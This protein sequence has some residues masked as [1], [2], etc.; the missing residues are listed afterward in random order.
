[1]RRSK[2]ALFFAAVFFLTTLFV[3]AFAFADDATAKLHFE[4]GIHLYDQQPPD[5]EG[6]LAEFR[7]AEKNKPSPGIKRNIALCLRALHRYGEAID[8][9]EAMLATGDSLKPATREAGQKMITEMNALIA[10]VKV[11]I[12]L[13]KSADKDASPIIPRVDVLVDDAPVAPEKLG[14]SLRV[15]PGEH[16]F[17]ARAAGFGDAMKKVSVVSGDRDVPVQLDLLPI[18]TAAE[19]GTLRVHAANPRAAIF[20]D[21]VALANGTWEGGLPAGK[22]HIEARADGQP[23]FAQDV[24][25]A[26]GARVDLEASPGS[27]GAI[28][29]PPP[30]AYSESG[31]PKAKE[32]PVERFWYLQGGV[33]AFFGTA[34]VS[35]PSDSTNA[36]NEAQSTDHGFGGLSILA[37]VGRKMTKVLS[38]EVWGEL[39]AM[40]PGA[41]N[42]RGVT[43]PTAADVTWAFGQI[44]PEIKIHSVGKFQFFAGTGLGLEL[45]SVTLNNLNSASGLG[46]T[47]GSGVEGVWLIEVGSQ[48]ISP[49]ASSFKRAF[50]WTWPETAQ[51]KIRL[52][53]SAT[54]TTR[55]GRAAGFGCNSASICDLWASRN[56][57]NPRFKSRSV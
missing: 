45:D 41:Y 7:A 54:S 27:T 23:T 20:I 38:L 15:G 2:R 24:D 1:M 44:G 46:S 21:G 10:T 14:T 42:V 18:A 3:S 33:G 28:T 32:K 30:P 16:L 35:G 13:H 31:K 50:F 53:I 48:L 40:K 51:S 26:P 55:P 25:V 6:A 5:Y 8:E 47:K 12:V 9:L 39:G 57:V 37:K 17:L 4:N 52:R 49:N 56:P 43:P 19:L 29:T 34:T 36:W 11:K 22:H